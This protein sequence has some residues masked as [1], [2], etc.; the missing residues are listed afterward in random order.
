MRAAFV[1]LALGAGFAV[2]AADWRPLASPAEYQAAIDLDTVRVEQRL[3]QFSVRRTYLRP[4]PHASGKEVHG[5][6]TH[7]LADCRAGSV[8]HVAVERFGENRKR[9]EIQGR[10]TVKRAEFAAPRPGSDVAEALG[11]A[12]A[13]VASLPPD[14]G[15][16][17]RAEPAAKPP[18]R[19]S[20]G[21][22]IVV[23]REGHVLTNEH[24]V[25]QCDSVELMDEANLRYKASVKAADAAKDLA[26][27]AAEA[28]SADVAIFRQDPL[29]RL[30]ESITIVGF[31]LVGVLGTRPTVGFG[32]VASIVGLR[33]NPAQMQISVPV[34]RGAS[35]GPVLDRSGHVIGV[36]VSKLDALKLAEKMGDLAQNVNFAVR[37]DTVR[38]FLEG[39]R[40]DFLV[41]EASARLENTD[42]AK[43]GAQVTVRVRC[44][45][46]AEPA[47]APGS[48]QK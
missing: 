30:G 34:Q 3:T 48:A 23:T 20:T 4:E 29:P 28:R 44:L 27:L 21:T 9:F 39:Q 33:G 10:K 14:A 12:C 13:K 18:A 19:S 26:L 36:V 17:K 40:V 24:V 38:A 47:A 2:R 32:H 41:S 37:G 16:G 46:A 5:T 42:L 1:L 11:L 25:R 43:R 22:G 35:G 7:Y 6:R 31:P 8:T 45:R 15:T